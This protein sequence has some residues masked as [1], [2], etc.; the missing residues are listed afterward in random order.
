MVSPLNSSD[1]AQ[2]LAR[3]ESTPWPQ[4]LRH[5]LARLCEG[6]H[7]ALLVGGTVRDA[8]MNRSA[9]GAYDVATDLTPDLVRARFERVEPI[10]LAH[11]T[12]LVIVGDLQI[13]CTTFRREGPYRDARHPDHVEFTADPI[14][15]LA[16]RDLTVNALAFD[17]ERGE[18]LDPFGGLADLARGVLR[19]VGDPEARFREDA[20]RPV[21]VARF[22]A[23]LEM[24]VERVTREALGTVR[25]RAVQ[26]APERVRAELEQLMQAPRPSVG[27]EL[28]REAG[29]LSLWMEELTRC[30]GVPQNRFHAHDVYTHSL[31]TCDAAPAGKPGVRWAALLHD[32]GKPDTRVERN[33][34]GT[35]YEHEVVGAALADRLLERLRFPLETRRAIVHLVREHMFAYRP[36]WSDGALRRWIRRVGLD[37]VADLFDLRIAD[38]I[39]NGLRTGFPGS[40]EQM[41]ER[42]ERLLAE[43]HAFGVRDLAVDGADVMR[44]LGIG[45]GPRV[46]AELEALLETVLDHPEWN[47]RETLLRRLAERRDEAMKSDRYA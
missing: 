7:R 3:L 8:L 22:A 29:L 42:I 37:S 23:T 1:P 15:D 40:L 19:A 14:A 36:E 41:R 11:G 30:V 12:V 28:L 5:A 47:E 26:V 4:P 46:G 21:R 44:V 24:E 38:V 45:P 20:L 18:L 6:G 39:G 10:G 32:I 2:A 25:D 9:R 16:R 34:E 33:G 43:S 13:E 17:L 27:L 35:F 31:L